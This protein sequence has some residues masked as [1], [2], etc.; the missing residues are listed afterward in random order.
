MKKNQHGIRA[1][2]GRLPHG[3]TQVNMN[4]EPPLS[5]LM[6][7]RLI[8]PVSLH[9]IS[10]HGHVPR[11]SWDDWTM[12][13]F[14]LVKRPTK[15]TMS[16]LVKAFP[17]WELPVT[18]VSAGNRGKELNLVKQTIGFNWGAGELSTSVW[19]GVRLCDVLKKCGMMSKKKGALY[20]YFDGSKN[21]PGG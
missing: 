14:G 6:D 15:F 21:L 9:Y 20:V 3:R 12:E 16:E 8:T 17:P 18:M 1:G 2:L 4:C 11:A 7:H 10:N 13:I 5:R 19:C